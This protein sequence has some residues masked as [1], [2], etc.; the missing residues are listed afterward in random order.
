MHW[1]AWKAIKLGLPALLIVGLILYV[2]LHLAEH[3]RLKTTNSTLSATVEKRNEA[4]ADLREDIAKRDAVL[5]RRELDYQELSKKYRA[6]QS[7]VKESTNSEVVAWRDTPLP[8]LVL[9][10]LQQRSSHAAGSGETNPA[11][12]ATE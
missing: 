2:K 1:L 12:N 5:A 3:A 9:S 8:P 7:A 4:I 11:D 6:N 10:L